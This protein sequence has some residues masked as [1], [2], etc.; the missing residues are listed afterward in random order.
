[1]TYPS[2]YQP[3]QGPY[4]N[5]DYYQPDVLAAARRASILMFVLGALSML[6]SFCCGGMGFLMPE[7][8]KNPDFAARFQ[9]VGANEHMM[10]IGMIAIGALSFIFGL[11]FVVLGVFVRRG[12]K[13]ATVIALVLS[14][15]AILGFVA[16]IISSLVV[17][18]GEVVGACFAV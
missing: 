11:A 7:L 6:G 4:P 10:R 12:S 13:T 18:P 8:M 1:M 9:E 5:F 2:P 17:S 3:P 16:N 14:I 15:L